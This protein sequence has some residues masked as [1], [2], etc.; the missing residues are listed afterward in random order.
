MIKK[1]MIL[2]AIGGT[3]Y[4]IL[5][6]LYRSR[7]HWSMFVAGGICFFFCG[8]INEYLNYD[9]SLIH[10]GIIGAIGITA[11]EFVTGC[12]V[13]ILLGLNVWD[14]THLPGNLIGQVCIQYSA[15]WI[16]VSIVA[17]V[18]DDYLR[19]WLFDEEKPDYKII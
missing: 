9:I 12:I 18:L 15:I 11:V 19:H 10:Q 4:C 6:L 8:L 16:G 5:E 13:N 1:N 14:Y 7:T 17:I 3:S 2:F